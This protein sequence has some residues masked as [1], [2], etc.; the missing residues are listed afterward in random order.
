[1]SVTLDT[2]HSPIGPCGPSEP[3][4]LGDNLRHASTALLS[5]ALDFGENTE[6]VA[7]EVVGTRGV[8]TGTV[9]TGA[10]GT[11]VGVHTVSDID[12]DEPAN[13]EL[14]LAFEWTQAAPQSFCLNDVACRNM[15]FILVTFETSHIE[16][17]PL[18]D[19]AL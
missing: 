14:L 2:S 4:P 12:P 17:E 19:V 9:G 16:M 3:S 6:V 18:K 5:S 7:T 1:M 15:S 11:G 13:I 8:G 10:V